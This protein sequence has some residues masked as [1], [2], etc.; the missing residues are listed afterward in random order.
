MSQRENMFILCCVI[1]DIDYHVDH[2][3]AIIDYDASVA[4]CTQ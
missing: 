1:V 2:F 3:V 4:N